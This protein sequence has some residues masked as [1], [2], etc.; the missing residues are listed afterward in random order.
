M[1]TSRKQLRKAASLTNDELCDW[2]CD[3][4][5]EQYVHHSKKAV[6]RAY[7]LRRRLMGEIPLGDATDPRDVSAEA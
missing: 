2:F 5:F 6:A 1:L 4:L 7:E 3:E